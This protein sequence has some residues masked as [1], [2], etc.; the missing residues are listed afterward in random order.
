MPMSPRLLR[1][2]ST[3][4]PEAA[5]W[6]ARVVSN[7][8]SVSGTTLS[9]VSKFCA[10]ISSAGIRDRFYRLNL[11]CGTGLNACLVPLYRGPS[12]SGTQYGNTTDTN[13]GPFVSG[14]YNETGASG[15]L[16]GN[17]SSK[18]LDTGLQQATVNAS[19]FGHL[20]VFARH[21]TYSSDLASPYRMIGVLSTSPT[22][23]YY[24]IDTRRNIASYGGTGFVAGHGSGDA[25]S[26]NAH[27]LAGSQL[28]LVSRSSASSANAYLNSTSV[29]SDT[30]SRSV[31]SVAGN[32][33]VFAENRVGTGA[34]TYANMT[35]GSYSIGAAMDST[36][37]AAYYTAL[38]AFQSALSR[39]SGV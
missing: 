37:V 18:Y 14:D 34:Q 17:G 3:V 2:R 11:F 32:V 15:G 20:S 28:M 39:N 4:H 29:A 1:P 5:A 8:G 25:V 6:A 12:L 24:Y 7:G 22:S 9:A 30:T 19:G 21:A 27:S 38:S 13:V 31:S 26:N 16:K 36:Q 35:L 23:Q 10:A 33:F